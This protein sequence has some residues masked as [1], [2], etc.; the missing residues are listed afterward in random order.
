[1]G[2]VEHTRLEYLHHLRVDLRWRASQAP[3]I[4]AQEHVG[5]RKGDALVPVNEWVIDRQTFQQRS[6]LG[7]DIVVVTRLRAEQCGLQRPWIAQP[8]RTAV[9]LHQQRVHA[10]HIGHGQVIVRHGLLRQLAVEAVK[11]VETGREHRARRDLAPSSG[12]RSPFD[13]LI[14][15]S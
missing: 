1:M 6:G 10:K 4:D 5:S 2:D 7:Q 3:T 15:N 13:R 8:K 9:T 12:L 14:R 11:F